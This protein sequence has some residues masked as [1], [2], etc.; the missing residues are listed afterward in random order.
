M[1]P[2][3]KWCGVIPSAQ[4]HGLETKENSPLCSLLKC[5][6]KFL[7]VE[8]SIRNLLNNKYLHVARFK[9]QTRMETFLL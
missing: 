2:L 9:P 7:A 6:I 5:Q 3:W 4:P 1:R 8:H